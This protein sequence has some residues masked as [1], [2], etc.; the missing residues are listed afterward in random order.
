MEDNS[1]DEIFGKRQVLDNRCHGKEIVQEIQSRSDYPNLDFETYNNGHKE[2]CKFVT[3][4]WFIWRV[5]CHSDKQSGND[6]WVGGCE[7][8]AN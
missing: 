8:T 2:G 5:Q 7:G 6:A 1:I 4:K 3:I